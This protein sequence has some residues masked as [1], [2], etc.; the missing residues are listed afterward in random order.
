LS[1]PAAGVDECRI[2]SCRWERFGFMEFDAFIIG[3]LP[4]SAGF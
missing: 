2:M 4:A 1:F 3:D